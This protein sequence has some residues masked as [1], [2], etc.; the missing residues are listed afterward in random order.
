MN[1]P[2]TPTR[3]VHAQARTYK[4]NTTHTYTTRAC[5]HTHRHQLCYS[6]DS[7][8]KKGTT[9]M[10]PSSG[11]PIVCLRVIVQHYMDH[12]KYWPCNCE[13]GSSLGCNELRGNILAFFLHFI[14]GL[15]WVQPTGEGHAYS[16][17]LFCVRALIFLA[18]PD[19][20]CSRRSSLTGLHRLEIC[21]YI[22]VTHKNSRQKKLDVTDS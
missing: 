22:F 12:K 5:A 20:P 16:V 18:C 10:K 17:S 14:F 1:R 13:E 15:G 6:T 9:N 2:K 19:I 3:R 8:P 4:T 7:P 11:K 21:D